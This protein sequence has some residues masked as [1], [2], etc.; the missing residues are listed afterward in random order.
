MREEKRVPKFKTFEPYKPLEH[1]EL[2]TVG[3]AAQD[4]ELFARQGFA[5]WALDWF[6][7]AVRDLFEFRL[8]QEHPDVKPFLG[9]VERDIRRLL[10]GE[11]AAYRDI[12]HVCHA[13]AMTEFYVD[14]VDDLTY[15]HLL[16]LV[17]FLESTVLE[18][19][20]KGTV[21]LLKRQYALRGLLASVPESGKLLEYIAALP[22]KVQRNEQRRDEVA[23]GKL[24]N[25]PLDSEGEP[26]VPMLSVQKFLTL[27]EDIESRCELQLA[28][29]EQSDGAAQQGGVIFLHSN[30][31][32][33]VWVEAAFKGV[34]RYVRRHRL[35]GLTVPRQ[36]LAAQR[37]EMSGESSRMRRGQCHKVHE[38]VYRALETARQDE[39]SDP[40][41]RRATGRGR[42]SGSGQGRR[43]KPVRRGHRRVKPDQAD[44]KASA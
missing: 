16:G 9:D 35:M 20:D 18:V 11:E 10:Y 24:R 14:Q 23:M 5:T 36:V 44:T 12:A 34:A 33:E 32:G 6:R 29:V 1:D 13:L 3:L 38:L 42:R 4:E 2:R 37:F 28:R 31:G 17:D 41:G 21:R 19:S 27:P 25:V 40:D 39:K 22:L 30:S 7:G 8:V 43:G 26:L 15:E